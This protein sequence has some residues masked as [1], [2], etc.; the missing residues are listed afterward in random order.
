MIRLAEMGVSWS[1]LKLERKLARANKIAHALGD[2]AAVSFINKELTN[3]KQPDTLFTRGQFTDTIRK[4]KVEEAN[5]ISLS[6]MG[7]TIY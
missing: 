6:G 2:Q 4:R 1:S 5:K 7:S 3:I